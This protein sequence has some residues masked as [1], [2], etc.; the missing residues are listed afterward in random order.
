MG[1]NMF[2]PVTLCTYLCPCA[3][4]CTFVHIMYPGMS[5]WPQ[6]HTQCIGTSTCR[7][8]RVCSDHKRIAA[9]LGGEE[10]TADHSAWC[11]MLLSPVSGRR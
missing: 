8:P 2:S 6:A 11:E 4:E 5:V 10:P 1:M 3:L 9:A 7:Q